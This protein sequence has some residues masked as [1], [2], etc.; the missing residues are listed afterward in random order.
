MAPAPRFTIIGLDSADLALVTA[1][2]RDGTLPNFARL[3]N[4]ALWGPVDAPKGFEAGAVWPSFLTGTPPAIHGYYGAGNLKFDPNNYTDRLITPETFGARTLGEALSDQSLRVALIDPPGVFVRP[5]VN[6]LQIIDWCTHDDLVPGHHDAHPDG[7]TRTDPPELAA[8]IEARFGGDPAGLCDKLKLRSEADFRRFRDRLIE[9]VRLK[10]AMTRHVMAKERWDLL[11]TVFTEAHCIGHH[12]WH[13]HDPR[14]ARHADPAVGALGDLVKAI[15]VE[16]DTALGALIEALPADANLLVYSSLGMGPNYPGS[17]QLDPVL[18]RLDGAGPTE[19]WRSAG[20][21]L[22]GIWR[23]IPAGVRRSFDPAKRLFLRRF[24]RSIDRVP[25]A[26]RRFFEVHNNDAT[27]GVRINLADREAYGR[28]QPGAEYE[29]LCAGLARDLLELVDAETRDPV[30]KRVYRTAQIHPGEWLEAMPDLLVE[31]HR[32]REIGS[33]AS[34]RIGTVRNHGH[35][36]RSGDHR[37]LGFFIAC[38]P[39]VEPRRRKQPISLYDLAPT[40]AAVLGAAMPD[41]QGR[42][43]DALAAVYTGAGAP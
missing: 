8:E 36:S 14:H 25:R 41:A 23:A 12:A 2:A 26:D 30:V 37:P 19:S 22:H 6:G 15:Y 16:T 29:D 42:P 27:G 1:W 35:A 43:N 18:A 11:L 33:V 13:F 24:G 34:P 17:P 3:L 31:Y 9:R 39:G 4:R 10:L 7:R 20:A 28:V 32:K 5:G 21:R 40:V 38:G